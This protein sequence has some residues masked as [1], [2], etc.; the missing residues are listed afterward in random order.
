MNGNSVKPPR[1]VEAIGAAQQAT[2]GAQMPA[3]MQRLF[4]HSSGVGPFGGQDRASGVTFGTITHTGNEANGRPTSTAAAAQS[5]FGPLLRNGDF[6]NDTVKSPTP[7]TRQSSRPRTP[8]LDHQLRRS[9]E[10][11][12][13]AQ[14]SILNLSGDRQRDARASPLPQAVQGAQ[15]APAG[16]GR[17][18]GIKMEFGR[19]F[20]GLGSG[21]GSTPQPTMNHIA[22]PPSRQS[23]A[24]DLGDAEAG[25][26]RMNEHIVRSARKGPSRMNE[27]SRVE[28]SDDGRAAIVAQTARGGQTVRGVPVLNHHHHHPHNHQ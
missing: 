24:S 10:E 23:P 12:H 1:P 18:A 8:V 14:R 2:T 5:S 27:D 3:P 16:S 17:E 28:S 25:A 4:S 26:R 11:A 20:S 13:A 6:H 22:Q 15:G 19:M 7:P 9:L 21:V